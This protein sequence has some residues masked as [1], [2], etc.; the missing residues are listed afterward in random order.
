M[1]ELTSNGVPVPLDDEH[2]APLTDST[3]LLDDAVALRK[4]YLE[5]G[6]LFL[7]G[8]VDAPLL[9]RL[10]SAYFTLFSAYDPPYLRPGTD[11]AEGIFS[12]V[13]HPALPAHGTKG[14]PAYEFVRSEDFKGFADSE[15]LCGLARK[16]LGGDVLR[17]PR[18]ILRHFDRSSSTASR[19]HVDYSYLDAG[20]DNLV[21]IW[22]PVGDC[23]LEAGALVYLEDSHRL[24]GSQLAELRQ[25]TDRPD[26][27]R[28]IS[29]DLA[30]VS[31]RLGRRWLWAD[32]RSGDVAIHSPH[33]VHASL[34]TKTDAMR[35]SADV[36][37]LRDGEAVDARWLEPWA[38]D[39]GN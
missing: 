10:R 13:R 33:T 35:M 25:V 7:R 24:G 15:A 6:Y 38:G 14:H 22:I 30:W 29:H 27:S 31:E 5:D 12:G 9:R 2:F 1:A 26:D 18:T 21:T 23:P 4:R 3:E 34:D 39:D 28:P 16:V 19:A 37:F 20:S 17:L 11:P 32:Y 36:R 8:V